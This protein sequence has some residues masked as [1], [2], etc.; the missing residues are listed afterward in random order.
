MSLFS[1]LDSRLGITRGDLTILTFVTA[2][3]LAG[4]LYTT[5]FDARPPLVEQREM[6]Q[7]VRR[8][9][10]IVALHREARLADLRQSA[11]APDSAPAWTPLTSEDAERDE[12]VEKAAAPSAS[13]GKKEA[14]TGPININSASKDAL[15]KLP[16]VGEKTA[17][18]IIA[19]RTHL[20][21]RK[22]E[23][24]MNVKGIGEKKFEKMKAYIAIK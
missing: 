19:M 12:I 18:A 5:F 2:T 7:M 9:D 1:N 11:A 6:R 15:M 17:E 14:L 3:A 16:G 8:H 4:F 13:S 21:F 22:P 23:D 24:I 20:P 10:S